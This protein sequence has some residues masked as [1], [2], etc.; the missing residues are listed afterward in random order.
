MAAPPVWPSAYL[1]GVGTPKYYM[2]FAAPYPAR[3]CP[4]QRFTGVL[5]GA[6]A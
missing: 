3:A 1:H 6:S 4:C 5:A 2:A